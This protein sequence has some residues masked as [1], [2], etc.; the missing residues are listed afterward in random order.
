M[1]ALYFPLG[2]PFLSAEWTAPHKD[3][4]WSPRSGRPSDVARLLQLGP[5][6]FPWVWVAPPLPSGSAWPT[7]SSGHWDVPLSVY[8]MA[9]P[10][11]ELLKG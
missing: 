7:A 2:L 4:R 3:S 11:R 6:V 10:A 8:N 1:K 5:R 9:P